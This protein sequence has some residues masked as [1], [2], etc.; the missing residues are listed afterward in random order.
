MKKEILNSRNFCRIVVIL[1]VSAAVSCKKYNSM[2]FTPGTGAPTISS[3]HTLSKT[4]TTVRYDTI[5]TYDASG[6]VTT[7][8]RQAPTQVN[9]FDSVTTAGNQ[10]QYY[11]I[12]GT[13][14]GST[15]TISFNGVSVYF[16]RA[17]ITDQSLIVQIPSTVP[18]IG[19]AATDTL[20]V[21]T[22]H[23]T[24]NYKFT[25]IPPPPTISSL[26]DYNFW[27]RVPNYADRSRFRQR[28]FGRSLR[29]H[30]CSYYS[31]PNG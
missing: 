15:T 24:A 28:V 25:I 22:L 26:T 11:V 17:W 6:N 31:Q 27:G 13:N 12:E 20:A 10:G 19:P 16:N 3:V 30:R 7:T 5:V 8:V 9:P 4:D 23:G 21:V 18:A 2:G 1:I 14:L 29:P